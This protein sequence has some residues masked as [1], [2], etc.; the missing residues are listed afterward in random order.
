MGLFKP[1]PATTT[2]GFGAV[3]APNEATS[4]TPTQTPPAAPSGPDPK[5]LIAEL[6]ELRKRKDL[7]ALTADEIEI[8][9]SS[10]AAAMI[11]AAHKR[12][13]EATAA[14][15]NAVAEAKRRA[16]AVLAEAEAKLATATS[17]VERATEEAQRQGQAI[18]AKAQEQAR[19]LVS[20]AEAETA[21]IRAELQARLADV[22]GERDRLLAAAQREADD[23]RAKAQAAAAEH[24][25]W[26]RT[27]IDSATRIQQGV[28]ERLESVASALS[29]HRETVVASLTALLG[30]TTEGN[31][32][33]AK[34][35]TAAGSTATESTA[36]AADSSSLEFRA[37]TIEEP[38]AD[39]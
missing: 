39:S 16:S 13:A 14:V 4:P 21:G 26:L 33:A 5:Q 32:A 27:Q 31:S 7:S 11:A 20:A 35:E 3:T 9:A 2:P 25:Q 1:K 23:L 28:S 18:V 29:S 6:N 34:S 24:E 15:E 17:T 36:D 12:Q 38:R 10:T 8:L 22:A 37:A 30:L 19:A